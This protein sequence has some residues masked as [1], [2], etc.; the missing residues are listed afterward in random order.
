MKSWR[1]ASLL[2]ALATVLL[3]QTV[4]APAMCLAT[5]SGQG[6]LPNEICTAEGLRAVHAAPPGDEATG[7]AAPGGGAHSGA[8][9]VCHALPQGADL[10]VPELPSPAWLSIATP[11]VAAAPVA[12]PQGIRGP[13]SGARAPPAIS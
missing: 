10:A 3:L 7:D 9:L 4:L 2:R 6:T 5:G 12:V 1:P 11:P 8:C 13:P